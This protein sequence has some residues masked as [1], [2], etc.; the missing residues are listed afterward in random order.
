MRPSFFS[1]CPPGGRGPLFVGCGILALC[2]LFVL[3]FLGLYF[4]AV[5]VA[6]ACYVGTLC[7]PLLLMLVLATYASSR[8]ETSASCA[9]CIGP[10]VNASFANGACPK[11]RTPF[12]VIRLDPSGKLPK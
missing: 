10:F 4:R 2:R 8:R 12:N 1:L 5:L 9:R 6:G 7:A 3:C 11:T